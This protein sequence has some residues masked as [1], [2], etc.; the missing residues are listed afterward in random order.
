MASNSNKSTYYGMTPPKPAH[1]FSENPP[2]PRAIDQQSLRD[3]R[4]GRYRNGPDSTP[5]A[6]L[7]AISTDTTRATRQA[8]LIANLNDISSRIG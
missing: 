8:E 2:T 5:L 4:L 3:Y 1:R 7:Q 6:S